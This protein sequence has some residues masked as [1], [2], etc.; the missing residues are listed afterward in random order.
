MRF[1]KIFQNILFFQSKIPE[2]ANHG[3][4]RPLDSVQKQRRGVHQLD[5]DRSQ[6]AW[7]AVPQP[8]AEECDFKPAQREGMWHKTT[9]R[10]CIID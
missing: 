7:N 4:F 2:H 6:S 3:D 10:E 9:R 1:N 8:V 5:S